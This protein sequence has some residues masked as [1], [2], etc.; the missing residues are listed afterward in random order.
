MDQ[1]QTYLSKINVLKSDIQSLIT[2]KNKESYEIQKQ[3]DSKLNELKDLTSKLKEINNKEKKEN[4]K[5]REIAQVQSF[6]NSLNYYQESRKK[7]DKRNPESIKEKRE[8]AKNDY[9]ISV[10]LQKIQEEKDPKTIPGFLFFH[11][12]I[13]EKYGL[14]PYIKIKENDTTETIEIQRQKWLHSQDQN[15]ILYFDLFE[16]LVE[17]RELKE[18]QKKIDELNEQINKCI[19]QVL[20]DS[21]YELYETCL[22][23]LNEYLS[24]SVK[25]KRIKDKY[26]IVINN[27]SILYNET[28]LPIHDY[29]S[30]KE[31]TVLR[32]NDIKKNNNKIEH[33]EYILSDFEYKIDKLKELYQK[34]QSSTKYIQNTINNLKYTQNHFIQFNKL[35]INFDGE[36]LHQN[37]IKQKGNYFKKWSKLND[38]ERSDRFLSYATYYVDKKLIISQIIDN[39]YREKLISEFQNN[40]INWYNTKILKYKSIK[41]NIQY[42][43]IENVLHVNF[44][45][46]K[47]EFDFNPPIEKKKSTDIK[48]KSVVTKS[49][50]T[51]ENEKIINEEILI[52]ILKEKQ[53][54]LNENQISDEKKEQLLEI[55]KTKLKLKRI[56]IKDKEDIY[57]KINEI[58]NVVSE[59]QV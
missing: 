16:K 10:N 39:S 13:I 53:N 56:L 44:D 14:C 5:N 9:M 52:F 1:K 6:V 7:D 59:N 43:I 20:S 42:G 58:Y 28:H 51:E 17:K 11:N 37:Q 31:K 2:D 22:N 21:Q 35:P 50:F 47:K 40:L 15:G 4:T 54:S 18:I 36:N 57:S 3:K 34:N 45:I 33:I 19:K 26:K 32:V 24:A 41:W 8:K 38:E 55:I 12:G 27:L 23:Y 25:T 46:N 29:L 30:E 49:L 48:K